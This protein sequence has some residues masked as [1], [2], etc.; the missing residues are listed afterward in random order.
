[1]LLLFYYE[2]KFPPQRKPNELELLREPKLKVFI[3]FI[4]FTTKPLKQILMMKPQTWE[5]SLHVSRCSAEKRERWSL[6]IRT[7]SAWVNL[8]DWSEERL[9][10]TVVGLNHPRIVTK[11]FRPEKRVPNKSLARLLRLITLLEEQIAVLWCR[12]NWKAWQALASYSSII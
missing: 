4:R 7:R 6:R 3:S 5:M 9:C 10:G 12:R 2:E 1:M 11:T 8:S